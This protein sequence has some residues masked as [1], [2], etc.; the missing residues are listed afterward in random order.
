[1]WSILSWDFDAALSPEQVTSNVLSNLHDG[2]II[3]MHDSLKAES[4]LKGSLSDIIIGIKEQGY[5]FDLL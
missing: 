4:N 5:D 3:V 1:M 2:A